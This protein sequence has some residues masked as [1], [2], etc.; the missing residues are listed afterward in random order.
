MW[1]ERP[2]RS[3]VVVGHSSFFKRLFEAHLGML[4]SEFLHLEISSEDHPGQ[5]AW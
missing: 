4:A 1:Q 5:C 3:I 2:E